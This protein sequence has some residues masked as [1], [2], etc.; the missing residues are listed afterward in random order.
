MRFSFSNRFIPAK[1]LITK[2]LGEQAFIFDSKRVQVHTLNETAS[3]IWQ[4]VN[5][6]HS[7]KQ[8]ITEICRQYDVSE[9]QAKKDVTEFIEKYIRKKMVE[10]KK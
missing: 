9:K 8:I 2:F 5:K 1:H 10:V 6:K 7:L 4:L 3:L